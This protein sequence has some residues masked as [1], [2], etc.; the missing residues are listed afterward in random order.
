MAQFSGETD[1][2]TKSIGMCLKYWSSLRRRIIQIHFHFIYLA[3][4][5]SETVSLICIEW[6]DSYKPINTNRVCLS[7]DIWLAMISS[8][9]PKK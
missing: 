6:G 7:I 9:N 1:R 2:K 5:W 3:I 8:M 4:E